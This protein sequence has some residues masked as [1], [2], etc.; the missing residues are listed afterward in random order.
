[1]DDGIKDALHQAYTGEA[2]AAGLIP[3]LRPLGAGTV[4]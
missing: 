1:M 3:R 4:G 2:K